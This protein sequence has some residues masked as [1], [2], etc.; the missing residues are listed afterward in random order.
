[1]L[2]KCLTKKYN[3]KLGYYEPERGNYTSDHQMCA[4]FLYIKYTRVCACGNP[5]AGAEGAYHSPRG[6]YP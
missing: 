5:G 6:C 1:M 3:F 4:D 2:L